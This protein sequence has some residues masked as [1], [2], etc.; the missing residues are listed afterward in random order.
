MHV[1][2]KE[3][4]W[5]LIIDWYSIITASIYILSTGIIIYFHPI[6]F[7]W[8][9]ISIIWLFIDNYFAPI[10]HFG[11]C[12]WQIF[13]AFSINFATYIIIII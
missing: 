11:H 9:G 2:K 5:T 1:C 13:I 8:F 7:F 10:K 6:I 3:I 12:L 4:M